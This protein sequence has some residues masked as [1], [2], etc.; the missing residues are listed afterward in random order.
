MV[1]VGEEEVNEQANVENVHVEGGLL[2]QNKEGVQDGG[3]GMSTG[4]HGEGPAAMQEA[5]EEPHVDQEGPLGAENKKE[6]LRSSF[7]RRHRKGR[8]LRQ[9]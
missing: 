4:V 2:L 1:A 8:V 3:Q 5:V 6:Q 9:I 7:K